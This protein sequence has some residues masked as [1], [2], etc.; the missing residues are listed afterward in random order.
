[1]EHDMLTTII[2]VEREVEERLAAE[3]RQAEERLARLKRDLAD[4]A[5]REGERLQEATRLALAAARTEAGERAAAVVR[6]A[7]DRGNQLAGLDDALLEAI[8]ARH[9]GRI[10]PEPDR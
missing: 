7:A 9:L 2:A 8:I 1:M 5:A 10:L 4:E 6:R 3:R